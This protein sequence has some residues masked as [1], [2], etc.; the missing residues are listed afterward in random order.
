M[1]RIK[2]RL[3]NYVK[4]IFKIV[5][6]KEMSILPGHLAFFLVLTIMPLL[7]LISY[8][9]SFFNLYLLDISSLATDF[10]PVEVAKMIFPILYST[11]SV[12]FSLFF[13]LAGF[14]IASNGA[15]S[16]ILVSNT[17]YNVKDRGYIS[18]RIKALLMT[19]MLMSIFVFS[20]VFLA[21]GDK[22]VEFIININII[23]D[24]SPVITTI[25]SK[26]KYP[27]GFII[28]FFVIKALYTMAPD[29]KISSK[30]VTK[31][32][33][34]TTIGWIA[35]TGIYSYYANHLAN[36]DLFYGGISNL[37]VLMIWIY[38]ISYIFVI[39]IAINATENKVINE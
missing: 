10:M 19:M 8:I 31:G 9:S 36:Y 6:L 22:I 4:K 5:N 15:H 29:I 20:L 39:G 35:V 34:F 11:A 18:R 2:N 16:I 3:F 25:F 30:K 28:I 27:V 21:F 23:P 1:K 33:I 38:I 24:L 14:F 37:I 13:M 32:A 12:K 17:L 26:I 7:T